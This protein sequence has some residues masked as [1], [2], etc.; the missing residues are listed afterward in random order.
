VPAL[1]L[2]PALPSVGAGLRTRPPAHTRVPIRRG[3]TLCL[4]PTT[5]T[6]STPFKTNPRLSNSPVSKWI[7]TVAAFAGSSRST[8]GFSF[9]L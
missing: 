9:A 4:P 2:T 3:R 5:H 8:G 7:C 6:D 1:R